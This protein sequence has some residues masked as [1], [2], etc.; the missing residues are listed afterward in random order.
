MV[1]TAAPPGNFQLDSW[2]RAISRGDRD[3][4]A[5]LYRA[6]SS[7]VYAYALS[8][9]RDPHDAEDAMHDSYVAV[10]NSAKD[11]KP[12]GK[13]MAWI[14][15]LTRNICLKQIRRQSWYI[16]LTD[17]N[18]LSKPG[19]DPNDLLM[20]RLC[21]EQLSDEDRQIVVLHAV[22]GMKHRQI[23]QLLGLKTSTVLSKYRRALQ[24]LRQM[25]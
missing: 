16:P 8:I 13:P 22:A 5:D 3:A 15:T 24:K 19:S 9:L 10:W 11:Y 18:A 25:L 2:L 7:A 14:M 20:L 12:Q 23:G 17:M 4:L 6:T 21:L 1:P